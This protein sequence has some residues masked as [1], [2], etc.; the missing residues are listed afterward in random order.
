MPPLMELQAPGAW[1]AV[2]F[3][4]DLHLD[5]SDAQT[6][7]A[8][9]RYMRDTPADAVF[10]LG[11]LFEVWVGDDSAARAGFE[12]DCVA[13]MK[14]CTAHAALF[15]MHGNRD[16]LVGEAALRSCNATL[17]SDPTV[18]GF[19]GDRYLLSHGDSL[20]LADT[21]YLV[22]RDKVRAPAWQHDFLSQPLERREAIGRDLRAQSEARK[23]AGI[24]YVDVD[25]AEAVRWLEA[26]D[27]R[28]L[29]HGHT[30]RPATHA[31]AGDCTR[32]VLSDW[33]ARATP[34]RHEVL[35]LTK[36]G[37]QRLPLA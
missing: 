3:V 2:D 28:V 16:F 23:A 33:D 14:A 7:Q 20:C 27:A 8:W 1:R 9:S 19:L 31:M 18:F 4:S 12:A 15:Y 30:H 34:P 26:A 32:V 5:A 24:E 36:G 17:L 25:E 37:F 6:F 21:D 11:D 22:F 29:I 35:R 13:V 10:I